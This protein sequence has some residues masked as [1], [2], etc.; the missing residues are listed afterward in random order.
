M[1]AVFA[2]GFN[3]YDTAVVNDQLFC[4][5]C[6]KNL[7]AGFFD[8]SLKVSGCT[9]SAVYPAHDA[10]FAV[11]CF[12]G[13]PRLGIELH[14]AFS[15][16]PVNHRTDVVDIKFKHS[17][18]IQIVAVLD[19]VL[20]H[21]GRGVI[22]HAGFFLNLGALNHNRTAV[23]CGCTPCER[24]FFN[25]N[26]LFTQLAGTNGSSLTGCT[27]ADNSNVRIQSFVLNDS[28]LSFGFRKFIDIASRL[29]HASSHCSQNCVTSDRGAADTV[30]SQTLAVDDRFWKFFDRNGADSR[31][32]F[33]GSDLDGFNCV[34]GKGHRDRNFT[35]VAL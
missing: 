9:L 15:C 26:D 20:C 12:I 3:A 10:R 17:S 21:D 19:V 14:A 35:A 7:G 5:G 8:R 25:Q 16:R 23:N 2:F 6:K 13:E 34:F 31:S 33:I 27:G 22:L 30:H 24:H 32:F 4:R 28:F 1:D 11:F 29:F 18:V